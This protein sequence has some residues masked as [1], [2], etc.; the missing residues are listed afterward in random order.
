M[1]SQTPAEARDWVEVLKGMKDAD[2]RSFINW[3]ASSSVISGV[4]LIGVEAFFATGLAISTA[5]V[6]PVAGLFLI[7]AGI[8]G[9]FP[10][11]IDKIGIIMERLEKLKTRKNNG[12]HNEKES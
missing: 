3:F 6:L 8:C 9:V 2:N 7:G 11:Y 4:G 12:G 5:P 10:E 1:L